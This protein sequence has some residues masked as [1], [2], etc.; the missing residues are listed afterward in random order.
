MSILKEK[1]VLNILEYAHERF[2]L[3]FLFEDISDLSI[4]DGLCQEFRENGKGKPPPR[5]LGLRRARRQVTAS[6]PTPY[7]LNLLRQ[8]PFYILLPWQF[9]LVFRD[10][11]MVVHAGQ[12]IL[13]EWLIF[14]GT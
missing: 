7:L 5:A 4:F 3:R 13:Y 8:K 14:P 6:L 10:K 1:K 9:E 12:G 11:E 2:N